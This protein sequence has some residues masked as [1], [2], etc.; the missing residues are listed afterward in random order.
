M[1]QISKAEMKK[2]WKNATGKK[3]IFYRCIFSGLK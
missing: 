3:N 2:Y 1:S